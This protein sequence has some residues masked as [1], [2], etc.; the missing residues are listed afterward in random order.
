[1]RGRVEN[2]YPSCDLAGK[3]NDLGEAR[4]LN[5]L[6]M[7]QRLGPSIVP[8]GGRGLRVEVEDE[9]VLAPLPEGRREMQGHGRL[10]ATALLVDK[11]DCPHGRFLTWPHVDMGG[12]PTGEGPERAGRFTS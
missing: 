7:G 4:R 3:G 8:F 9:N 10:P 1:M 11:C 2:Q 6:D 5:R 12:L